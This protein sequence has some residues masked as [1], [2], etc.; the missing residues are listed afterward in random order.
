MRSV[1]LI[2]LQMAK[3]LKYMGFS[4]LC[5]IAFGLFM[6]TWFISRHILYL[7]VCKSVWKDIPV[8][9]A[10]GCYKGKKGS[11]SGPFPPPDSFGHLIDPFRN[12]EGV[13]CF[14]HEIKWA[15]LTCLLFLQCLTLMWFWM[16]CRVAAK[17]L[18]GGQ[19]EDT[20]SDDEDENDYE[21]NEPP[22][23]RKLDPIEVAP[24][25]EEVGV[26]S[27]SLK[28]RT[29]ASKR[30]KKTSSSSSGVMLPGHSDRKELLGRIGCD[31]SP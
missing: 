29:A 5:D 26:E 22:T 28:G 14:N 27:I 30:Y 16:I 19:A 17:V 3:C 24:L 12:P 21:E 20:R 4:T 1:T 25:E 8:E 9:I 15:F 7:M 11:L 31:K 23:F 13:V 18:S 6:I 2:R 10:Y